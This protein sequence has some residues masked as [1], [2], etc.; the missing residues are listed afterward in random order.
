MYTKHSRKSLT[1]HAILHPSTNCTNRTIAASFPLS[2]NVDQA[3]SILSKFGNYFIQK[4]TIINNTNQWVIVYNTVEAAN[5][6]HVQKHFINAIDGLNTGNII[7]AIP[8]DQAQVDGYNNSNINSN[9]SNDNNNNNSNNDT[10]NN[11]NN[12]NISNTIA[13]N[14]FIKIESVN[15]VNTLSSKNDVN[16]DNVND[17]I[18]HKV[19][20]LATMDIELDNIDDN[21]EVEIYPIQDNNDNNNNGYLSTCV[22]HSIF[23]KN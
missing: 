11:N 8:M 15:K 5:N 22:T 7:L 13:S 2:F 19:N 16:M 21:S 6:A 4:K 12:N 10:N 9:N 14:V 17:N 3:I 18:E 20:D 23:I 1:N